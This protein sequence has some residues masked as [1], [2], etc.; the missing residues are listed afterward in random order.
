MIRLSIRVTILEW[1]THSRRTN[2]WSSVLLKLT[3]Y[4]SLQV[5]QSWW[6]ILSDLLDNYADTGKHM[7][8]KFH[9]E[10]ESTMHDGRQSMI[11]E[12]DSVCK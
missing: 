5:A 9:S 4:P 1:L 10:F 8:F 3:V 7:D 12:A 6:V 11:V 2:T